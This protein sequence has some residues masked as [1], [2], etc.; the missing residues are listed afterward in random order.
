MFRTSAF[1]RYKIKF[2]NHMPGATPTHLMSVHYYVIIAADHGSWPNVQILILLENNLPTPFYNKLPLCAESW[3]EASCVV[4]RADRERSAIGSSSLLCH[5][6]SSAQ[7]PTLAHVTIFHNSRGAH[8]QNKCK[9]S[10]PR[11]DWLQQS[12]KAPADACCVRMKKRM[13]LSGPAAN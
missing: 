5:K 7:H 11:R 8:T 6:N 1:C 13:R 2:S 9:Q 3:K 12:R 10:V 4:G